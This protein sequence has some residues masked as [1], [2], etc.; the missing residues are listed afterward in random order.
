MYYEREKVSVQIYTITGPD[1][2]FFKVV[3]SRVRNQGSDSYFC[4]NG[5]GGNNPLVYYSQYTI[6]KR[7]SE[8]GEEEI[9]Y[10]ASALHDGALAAKL[11]IFMYLSLC[12]IVPLAAVFCFFRHCFRQK[13]RK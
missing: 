9:L 5:S 13:L 2:Y 7:I 8:D 3:E 11:V 6:L 12:L 10:E 1:N 4:T